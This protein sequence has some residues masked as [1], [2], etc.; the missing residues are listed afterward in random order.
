MSQIQRYRDNL[1]DEIDGAALYTAMSGYETDEVRK[2]LYLQ[3]AQAE[4]EHADVWR[5]KLMAAGISDLPLGASFKTRLLIRLARYFGPAF[6]LPV[7]AANEY[8]DRNKYAGQADAVEMS[9]EEQ[10]HAA[11]IRA[12]AGHGGP[13]VGADIAGAERWHRGGS[14]NELRAAVLGVNDGLVS[15]FCLVMGVAGA[16]AASATVLLT[17]AAAGHGGPVVGADIAGAERWHR[18]GSGN[19]LRAA[20]LGVND[21]LVSNFCLVM[22]VAGAGAASAT[23]LLTGLAGLVAGALSMALGEWLSVTNARELARTQIDK[24]AEELEQTP[25]AEKKELALIYQAKG[26]EREQA[27]Q[28]ATKVMENRDTALETLAREELGIDPEEL[29][30][31][32]WSAAGVSLLLFALGAIFPVLPF[33]WLENSNAIILSIVLSLLGL[34]AVGMVTSLFNGRSFAFSATRQ[35]LFGGVAAAITF[36]IGHLFGAS[37]T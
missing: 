21:G 23:V 3:L 24:E 35:I 16:G 34:G 7:V 28:I 18:G 8:T 6:V 19:E 31:N 32:P 12:A 4:N 17:R 2:D 14:G 33:P 20:V 30:G 22:G 11:V 29:G 5:K 9:A 1:Q 37:I 26:I 10:G 25:E 27:W 15:N 13:V 36:G